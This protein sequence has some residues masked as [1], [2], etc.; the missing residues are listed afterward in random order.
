MVHVCSVYKYL[1]KFPCSNKTIRTVNFLFICEIK[2][3]N[4][5]IGKLYAA[6]KILRN[7][8][9]RFY[10]NNSANTKLIN[11]RFIYTQI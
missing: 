5:I 8:C 11:V 10:Y 2:L 6:V 9:L 3:L 7:V 4:Q 1:L